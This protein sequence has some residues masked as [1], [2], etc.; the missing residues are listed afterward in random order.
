MLF[1]GNKF[2]VAAPISAFANANLP[3]AIPLNPDAPPIDPGLDAVWVSEDGIQ[4]SYEAV[5]F[6]IV[7]RTRREFGHSVSPHLF[8]DSVATAVAVDNPKHIVDASLILGR[9]EH[10]TTE[11][12]YNH[13]RS[14]GASRC[15]AA[16]F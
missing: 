10:R 3:E 5:A 9:A 16:R 11:K 2:H 15:S 14:L 4:L 13:G 7:F 1:G 8:R 6:Q 12:F